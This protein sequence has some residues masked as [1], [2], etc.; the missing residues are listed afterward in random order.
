[1][2][3]NLKPCPFCG[4]SD[5]KFVRAPDNWIRCANCGAQGPMATYACAAW[6]RRV[7]DPALAELEAWLLEQIDWHE[8]TFHPP[9]KAALIKLRK[10]KSGK[11][12]S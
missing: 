7:P 10:L 4:S 11:S 9:L 8:D 1:M 6:N 2:M 12:D 5:L 3:T